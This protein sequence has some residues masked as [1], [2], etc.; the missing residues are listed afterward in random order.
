MCS[1]ETLTRHR[2]LSIEERLKRIEEEMGVV[3]SRTTL[4][5]YYKKNNVK[6]LQPKKVLRQ[7]E[8]YWSRINEE[9][10]QFCT[11]LWPIIDA[12]RV[13]YLDETSCQLWNR[14][15]KTWM[16]TGSKRLDCQLNKNRL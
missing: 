10:R 7:T 6:Y 14:V 13:I 8:A 2:F 12:Q 15:P 11:K 5:A 1:P 9:R 16:G 3:M 4:K